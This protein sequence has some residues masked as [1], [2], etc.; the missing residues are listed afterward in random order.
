MMK[1][2]KL[3]TQ[4]LYA[5][6]LM[7]VALAGCKIEDSGE[8]SQVDAGGG[9]A[10]GGAPGGGQPS[11]G[12]PAG[13]EPAGGAPAGGAPAG[14]APV[15]GAPVG[16]APVGGAPVGGAPVGGAP[17]GGAPVGGAPVGGAPVGGAPVGGAPVGGAPVGGAPVG[18]APIGGA[19]VGGAPVGGAPVGGAPVPMAEA[20]D[21]AS[22][23]DFAAR[24]TLNEATGFWTFAGDTNG[25]ADT[26]VPSCGTS[27]GAGDT[28]FTFTVPAGGTWFFTTIPITPQFRSYDTI[29]SLRSD[30][31]DVATTLD[32]NDDDG[33]NL[34]SS[35]T[36]TL[37]AG[38]T[39]FILVDGFRAN[40]G[41]FEL[42]AGL[43]PVAALGEACGA[44]AGFAVCPEGAV[45]LDDSRFDDVPAVCAAVRN[46][47]TGDACIPGSP[48][49]AC[50]EEDI[51]FEDVC[52]TVRNLSTG[53][54]CDRGNP[55]AVCPESD[56]CFDAVC[57]TP[58]VLNT[59]D[60]CVVGSPA[61]C[62]PNDDCIAGTC[63][64]RP[65]ECPAEYG[66][67]FDLNANPGADPNTW[68]FVGDTTDGVLDTACAGG[69]GEGAAM[70]HS[71]LVPADGVYTFETSDMF[72]D[73]VVYVRESCGFE[74]T[75]LACNDDGGEGT[76]SLARAR[77]SAGQ[78]VYVFVDGF[79]RLDGGP[80]T[81]TVS[82][83]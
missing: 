34:Q 55:T 40:V 51:C 42:T 71:F 28:T 30:C 69:M 66:A 10:T 50:P 46:L 23:I 36:T 68:V 45:C 47:N 59:G 5:F 18:G 73:T 49:D 41:P 53:D 20:S 56:V 76:A 80:Y 64:V 4:T 31:G 70:V 62:G 22:P 75:E 37:E 78:T 79:R 1:L 32:C 81:L 24:A 54:A 9:G 35:I 57:V 29:L 27:T 7:T 83:L 61:A 14:G 12:T 60:A 82:A 63:E 33:F 67:V 2:E 8:G 16:G 38:Q 58:R 44:D 48:L 19:P 74:S 3:C 72:V 26:S 17:V 15:G 39:V 11:G 52:T 21:C 13:G 6:S 43:A 77:L 25:A 65:D